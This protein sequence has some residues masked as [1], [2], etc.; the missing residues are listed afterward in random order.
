MNSEEMVSLCRPKPEPKTKRMSPS[1][2]LP[3][4]AGISELETLK[5]QILFLK[6]TSSEL[7]QRDLSKTAAEKPLSTRFN[8]TISAEIEVQ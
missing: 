5:D 4:E 6:K 2:S 8:L 3:S 7:E 1:D